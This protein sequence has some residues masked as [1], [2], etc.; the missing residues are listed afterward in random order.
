MTEPVVIRKNIYVGLAFTLIAVGGGGSLVCAGLLSGSLPIGILGGML[1]SGL[2]F[3]LPML[4]RT[5]LD[6]QGI[7]RSMLWSSRTVQWTDVTELYIRKFDRAPRSP[8]SIKVELRTH[9]RPM[10]MHLYVESE[11]HAVQAALAAWL[12]RSVEGSERVPYMHH[13]WRER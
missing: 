12:P 4:G 1:L 10:V 6:D 8:P 13:V 3:A 2:W 11:A 7:H 5:Q 9:R